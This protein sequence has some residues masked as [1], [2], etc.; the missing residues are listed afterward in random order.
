MGCRDPSDVAVQPKG[1]VTQGCYDWDGEVDNISNR[2]R[3]P[4]LAALGEH[5]AALQTTVL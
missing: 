5:Q 3:N 1:E 2:L 4:T